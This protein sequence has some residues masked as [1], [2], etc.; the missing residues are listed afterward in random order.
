MLDCEAS[1]LSASSTKT[2]KATLPRALDVVYDCIELIGPDPFI[3]VSDARREVAHAE[4]FVNDVVDAYWNVP[5]HPSERKFFCCKL[6]QKY[7][8]FLR[9]TQGYRGG[10]LLWTR[11]KKKKKSFSARMAQACCLPSEL[12]TNVYVDD[13]IIAAY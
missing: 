7:Y 11:G 12:R 10:P 13:P 3:E 6:R 2:E 5:I 1:G 9:A 4:L 8:V